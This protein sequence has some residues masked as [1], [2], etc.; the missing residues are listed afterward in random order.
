[1]NMKSKDFQHFQQPITIELGKVDLFGHGQKHNRVVLEFNLFS[2]KGTYRA[3]GEEYCTWNCIV[4]KAHGR[5]FWF[6][7]TFG[8]ALNPNCADDKALDALIQL[9]LNPLYRDYIIALRDTYKKNGLKYTRLLPLCDVAK[10]CDCI[11]MIEKIAKKQ[12]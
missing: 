11:K 8:Y 12:K 5:S 3:A 2:G 1:M 7:T 10:M 6:T 4:Y 9:G